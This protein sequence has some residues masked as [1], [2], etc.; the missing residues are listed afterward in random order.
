M[1][2]EASEIKGGDTHLRKRFGR[3]FGVLSRLMVVPNF[4]AAERLRLMES[5]FY[6]KWDFCSQ[7]SQ[8]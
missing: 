6:L 2:L 7:P 8:S 3:L 4:I 1:P 5:D